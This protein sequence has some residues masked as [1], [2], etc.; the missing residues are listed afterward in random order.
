MT[1]QTW[2]NEILEKGYEYQIIVVNKDYPVTDDY[3]LNNCLFKD[4]LHIAYLNI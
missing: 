1:L 4:N 2:I 3:L